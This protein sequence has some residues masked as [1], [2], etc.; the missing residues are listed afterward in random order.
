MRKFRDFLKSTIPNLY[1]QHGSHAFPKD[2][3][4]PN[5]YIQHGSHA[6]PKDDKDIPNVYIDHGSHSIPPKKKIFGESTGIDGI[7]VTTKEVIREESQY[8]HDEIHKILDT[9]LSHQKEY[10]LTSPHV[11]PE[12]IDKA[13]NDKDTYVRAM[14]ASSP[15]ASH[16][17][18][19]KAL[20]DKDDQVVRYTLRNKSL[21]HSHIDRALQN[22]EENP[23]NKY[24][25]HNALV[26]HPNLAPHHID[27]LMKTDDDFIARKLASNPNLL[28]HHIDHML[29]KNDYGTTNRLLQNPALKSEHIDKIMDSGNE[30]HIARV[31][32][33]PNIQQHHIDKA[34]ESP[35]SYV[36]QKALQSDKITPEHL[37]KALDDPDRY[38][39]NEALNHPK[40]N[41]EHIN[42]IINNDSY[43][44][45]AMS[46]LHHKNV[47]PEHIDKALDHSSWRVRR[48]AIRSD[49][50]TAAHID[51][52]M[53]DDEEDVRAEAVKH[54]LATTEHI[55]KGFEDESD[56]V[57]QAA[58]SNPKVGGH[59]L[60]KAIQHG[61]PQTLEALS[62]HHALEPHHIDHI[63]Q[64]GNYGAKENVMRH[65]SFSSEHI[66][67][68]IN[69]PDSSSSTVT[70]IASYHPDKIT[71]DH[72]TKVLN[73]PAHDIWTKEKYLSSKAVNSSHVDQVLKGDNYDLKSH[74]INYSDHLSKEHLEKFA[75]DLSQPEHLRLSASKKLFF[76][77][78]NQH[79]GQSLRDVNKH[80]YEKQLKAPT[81]SDQMPHEQKYAIKNYTDGSYGLNKHLYTEGHDE[82]AVKNGPYRE[83]VKHLDAAL[84]SHELPEMKVYSGV[85]FH[86]KQKASSE[87]LLKTTAFLSTSTNPNTARGFS[88]G[89]THEGEHA[90]HMLRI[91]VPAG[92]P[93]FFTGNSDD[94]SEFTVHNEHEVMLPRNARFKI[95]DKPVKTHNDG[96]GDI[97]HMWDA[98]LVPHHVEN[99]HEWEPPAPKSK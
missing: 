7:H 84:H 24:D 48:E 73:N 50:V 51:K 75:D 5:V 79:L 94:G 69:N 15:K 46:V 28:P 89:I 13:L 59:L 71:A 55:E 86:P 22:A 97:H 49:K 93:G 78:D 81:P 12:H 54:R 56:T 16:D 21:N 58:A 98:H 68:V 26:S 39:R 6:F 61:S 18:I 42:N 53:N 85:K 91:H 43:G 35:H 66:D 87:G 19:M 29:A 10:A 82:E 25:I 20:G 74:L 32:E 70:D 11:T 95:S 38:V 92:H 76:M 47:T 57:K 9:G 27:H 40:L 77:H 36:R 99:A 31:M 8:S 3:D 37:S 33:N 96:Y 30:E 44:D 63:L 1:I 67:K 23:N 41:A 14:A 2:A 34:M 17:N 52:A 62:T 90:N 45:K 65:P 60:D 88:R 72:V 4:I 80:L 83:Q 64:H